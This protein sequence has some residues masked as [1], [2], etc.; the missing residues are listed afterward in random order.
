MIDS[1]KLKEAL[2]QYWRGVPK[3][4]ATKETESRPHLTQPKEGA[5]KL[6]VLRSTEGLSRRV[7]M[8]IAQRDEIEFGE[9]RGA[10]TAQWSLRAAVTHPGLQ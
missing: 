4:M 9:L 8:G 3:L 6:S 7:S 5:G 10:Q 2:T 1:S